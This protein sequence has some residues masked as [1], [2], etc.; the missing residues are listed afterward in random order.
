MSLPFDSEVCVKTK[1]T[2]KSFVDTIVEEDVDELDQEL[3][4]G[5]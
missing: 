1:T 2:R 4:L 5:R 3:D